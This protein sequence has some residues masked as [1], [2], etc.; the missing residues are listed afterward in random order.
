MIQTI[1]STLFCLQAMLAPGEL[2]KTTK[3]NDYVT[4]ETINN[5]KYTCGKVNNKYKCIKYQ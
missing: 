1:C 4:I 2:P 3:H 5:V